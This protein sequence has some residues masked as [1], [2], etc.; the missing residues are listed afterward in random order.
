MEGYQ[1][2]FDDINVVSG[3]MLYRHILD[4][5]LDVHD[6]SWI[7]IQIKDL[8][9]GEMDVDD[10][11]HYHWPLLSYGL[12]HK[13]YH[14][15]IWSSTL[16]DVQLTGPV[17]WEDTVWRDGQC[18]TLLVSWKEDVLYDRIGYVQEE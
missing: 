4:L 14:I 5:M 18:Y 11:V 13:L 8:E 6:L 3:Q 15:L 7:K 10:E 12:I 1:F 17:E 16:F 2:P 9:D